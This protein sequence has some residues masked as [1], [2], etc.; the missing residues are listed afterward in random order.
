[1]N[2]DKRG[3]KSAA[4]VDRRWTVLAPKLSKPTGDD[5]LVIFF[6]AH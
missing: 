2:K 3:E 6:L 4:T 5:G 1:M